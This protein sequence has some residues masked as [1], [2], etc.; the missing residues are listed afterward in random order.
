MF[1]LTDKK[2]GS[3]NL[4]TLELEN[5]RLQRQLLL[6]QEQKLISTN[7]RKDNREG[8]AA[9]TIRP[10]QSQKAPA[11]Q[12]APTTTRQSLTK[13]VQTNPV[14]SEEAEASALPVAN[15]Y[16]AQRQHAKLALEDRWGA[17][18]A[19]PASR[20]EQEP[21]QKTSST[22]QTQP[23]GRGRRAGR[24]ENPGDASYQRALDQP[25]T[26]KSLK[27][28]KLETIEEAA[29][30]DFYDPDEPLDVDLSAIPPRKNRVLY[31][32]KPDI[33]PQP[34]TNR[35]VIVRSERPYWW[36]DFYGRPVDRR[37]RLLE[38]L[39]E[40]AQK[41]KMKLWGSRLPYYKTYPSG[42]RLFVYE[43]ALQDMYRRS[44][45]LVHYDPYYFST[46]GKR[47]R[48]AKD[49]EDSETLPG[50]T[51]RQPA[52]PSLLLGY[53]QNA[54][55]GNNWP[56]QPL[57]ENSQVPG[58]SHTSNAEVQTDP[59]D[60]NESQV[61]GRRRRPPPT[62][63]PD[64][65]KSQGAQPP[66]DPANQEGS[67]PQGPENKDKEQVDPKRNG[68]GKGKSTSKSVK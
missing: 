61:T 53:G 43:Q 42:Q 16:T 66:T 13:W 24:A 25:D 40:K 51:S 29:N 52:H 41:N 30:V 54:D 37:G 5:E 12:K 21:K 64:D 67:P 68:K 17:G 44:E 60:L 28:E 45:D 38:D 3:S 31:P 55:A 35:V 1:L 48:Y 58:T 18:R 65:G 15:T 49:L 7:R 20:P 63:K 2:D 57:Q 50:Y 23:Q 32:Y 6:L 34:N 8:R 26:Y 14:P 4:I 11:S 10:A 22:T 19:Q 27:P 33:G 56:L 62:Q 9:P 59:K 39:D 36:V 46:Y 47:R